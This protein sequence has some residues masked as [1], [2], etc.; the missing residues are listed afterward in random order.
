MTRMLVLA[1]AVLATGCTSAHIDEDWAKAGTGTAQATR[2][3]WECRR[4]EYD[5]APR[6]P[7]PLIGGFIDATRAW[8]NAEI[9]EGTY[10]RCMRSRGYARIDRPVSERPDVL[11]QRGSVKAE[12]TR[13]TRT[14]RV[15]TAPEPAPTRPES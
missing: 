11:V 13:F 1:L 2:D 3:D 9:A 14:P 7:T 5:K 10:R 8:A 6:I 4:V 15:P 12:R